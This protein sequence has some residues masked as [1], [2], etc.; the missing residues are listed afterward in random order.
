MGLKN[1]FEIAVVNE[2]SVFRSLKFY[3]IF[4]NV[5]HTWYGVRNSYLIYLVL[6]YQGKINKKSKEKKCYMQLV[7]WLKKMIKHVR[8]KDIQLTVQRKTL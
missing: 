3:C 4:F 5:L 2:L 7:Y 1:W 6:C 8:L